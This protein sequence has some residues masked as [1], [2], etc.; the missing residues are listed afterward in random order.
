[1]IPANTVIFLFQRLLV[2][3][4]LQNRCG[5]SFL[6]FVLPTGKYVTRVYTGTN[7]PIK[8]YKVWWLREGSQMLQTYGTTIVD[9]KTKMKTKNADA[10]GSEATCTETMQKPET[11][12]CLTKINIPYVYHGINSP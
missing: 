9:A 12:V 4:R 2:I 11:F 6:F 7:F 10:R 1:M 5:D 3:G 8:L